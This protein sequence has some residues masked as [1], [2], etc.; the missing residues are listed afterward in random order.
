MPPDVLV[1]RVRLIEEIEPWNI[2]EVDQIECLPDVYPYQYADVGV[3]NERRVIVT[4]QD[5]PMPLGR[6][7]GYQTHV[8][9][10]ERHFNSW[11]S[12][13]FPEVL[14]INVTMQF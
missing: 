4:P 8:V 9:Y 14:I 3:V 1:S 10:V 11:K 2:D 5:S 7:H 6:L 13:V 12:R